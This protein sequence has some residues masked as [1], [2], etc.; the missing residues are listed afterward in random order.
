MAEIRVELLP[1]PCWAAPS[2]NRADLCCPEPSGGNNISRPS[3]A[4]A[5]SSFPLCFGVFTRCVCVFVFGIKN[6]LRLRPSLK[7]ASVPANKD[8]FNI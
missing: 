7:L 6:H 1:E 2:W 5:P 3:L 4:D 8:T